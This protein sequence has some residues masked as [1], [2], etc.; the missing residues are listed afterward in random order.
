MAQAS[1]SRYHAGEAVQC[2][3][4][5]V[6]DPSC[7][8]WPGSEPVLFVGCCGRKERTTAQEGDGDEWDTRMGHTITGFILQQTS[9]YRNRCLP[10]PF[11]T[12]G[13]QLLQHSHTQTE[14]ACSNRRIAN[15]REPHAHAMPGPAPHCEL[16]QALVWGS[17]QRRS[18]ATHATAHCSDPASRCKE[19]RAEPVSYLRSSFV[20]C[21]VLLARVH[22]SQSQR[23]NEGPQ[24]QIAFKGRAANTRHASPTPHWL[25]RLSLTLTPLALNLPS[26]NTKGPGAALR[27][28]HPPPRSRAPHSP[29]RSAPPPPHK[30]A[31]PLQARLPAYPCTRRARLRCA[32]C[33]P[34]RRRRRRCK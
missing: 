19:R 2:T 26:P 23:P 6:G 34:A 21:L 5:S 29:Q 25:R 4:A 27:A 13:I 12:P 15:A 32:A 18:I 30:T 33:P 11:V 3:R 1:A 7:W 8:L 9:R 16:Q 14:H 17:Q 24:R 20:G 28:R 31:A 22:N 10:C